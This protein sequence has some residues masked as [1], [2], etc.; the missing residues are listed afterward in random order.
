M[1]KRLAIDE[2]VRRG[3]DFSLDNYLVSE[4]STLQESWR[5]I[6]P[7]TPLPDKDAEF[8]RLWQGVDRGIHRPD[9]DE[10]TSNAQ[11]SIYDVLHKLTARGFEEEPSPEAFSAIDRLNHVQAAALDGKLA[12]YFATVAKHDRL[13]EKRRGKRKPNVPRGRRMMTP[14]LPIPWMSG[15]TVTGSLEAD[16]SHRTRS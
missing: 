11:L 2:E 10:A 8:E 3:Y 13:D 15:L 4:S 6:G 16:L 1:W 7:D 5:E 12:P 14:I 9:G